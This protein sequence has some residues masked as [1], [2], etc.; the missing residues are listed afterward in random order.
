MMW[1]AERPTDAMI[2]VGVAQ[3]R[4]TEPPCADGMDV[5]RRGHRVSASVVDGAGHHQDVVRYAAVV[6]PVIT[7]TGIAL[8]GLAALI[9]AGQM[10][11]AYDTPPHTCA[12]F[13]AMEANCVTQRGCRFD[14]SSG[15][16]D[17]GW[18]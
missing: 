15:V 1:T 5:Q 6:P 9:T 4:G 7:H 13:A 14:T 2:S 3:R 12:V 10:A 11:A 8:G 17:G 16:T 18:T